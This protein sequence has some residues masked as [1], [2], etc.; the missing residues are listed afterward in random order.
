MMENLCSTCILYQSVPLVETVAIIFINTSQ[1]PI[2][3]QDSQSDASNFLYSNRKSRASH[4][5]VKAVTSP[6]CC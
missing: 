6:F 5:R 4:G 1:S 3:D 2:T